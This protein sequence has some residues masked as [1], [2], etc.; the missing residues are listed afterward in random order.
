[1]PGAALPRWARGLGPDASAHPAGG[2]CN[3][4]QYSTGCQGGKG[5]TQQSE[6]QRCFIG[7][8]AVVNTLERTP[9]AEAQHNDTCHRQQ[10]WLRKPLC[11]AGHCVGMPH[12]LSHSVGNIRGSATRNALWNLCAR[13]LPSGIAMCSA[14][15]GVTSCFN[16]SSNSPT[17]HTARQ[18][19]AR[20]YQGTSVCVLCSP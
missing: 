4:M 10:A 6:L 8:N 1:V 11:S 2:G 18:R 15:P 16:S 13:G 20:G 19:A 7:P 12:A 5:V 9:Q 17:Q 3:A 14:A